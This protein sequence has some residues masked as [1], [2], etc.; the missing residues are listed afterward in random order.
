M[1]RPLPTF[2]ITWKSASL[3]V[4]ISHDASMGD[5]WYMYLLI[6][7]KNQTECNL[8]VG[9][10]YQFSIK[11]PCDASWVKWHPSWTTFCSI[12]PP[13]CFCILSEGQDGFLLTKS[14]SIF[15]KLPGSF[16]VHVSYS[17]L[18]TI[19]TWSTWWLNES[20]WKICNRPIGSVPQVGAE[21]KTYLKPPPRYSYPPWN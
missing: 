3:A 14:T 11:F 21:N 6:Y 4:R 15:L 18:Q 7:H 13:G 20:I 1:S 12:E 2:K 9:K 17:Y 8:N 19:P 10:I 5:S 16:E